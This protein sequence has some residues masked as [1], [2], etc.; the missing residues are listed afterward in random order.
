VSRGPTDEQARILQGYVD[1]IG[2][3]A[4]EYARDAGDDRW[5]RSEPVGFHVLGIAMLRMDRNGG[6]YMGF[7]GEESPLTIE[8]FACTFSG[9]NESDT[10]NIAQG[11]NWE[12]AVAEGDAK[13]EEFRV[14]MARRAGRE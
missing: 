2:D 4:R 5:L 12:K 14:A 3:Y 13:V 11:W 6:I 9:R 7:G 8:E 1:R 10:Y